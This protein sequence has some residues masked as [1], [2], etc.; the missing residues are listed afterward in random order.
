MRIDGD[1]VINLNPDTQVN[2]LQNQFSFDFSLA[3]DRIRNNAHNIR[4]QMSTSYS[5]GERSARN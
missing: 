5:K 3:K 4:S 2:F 1:I